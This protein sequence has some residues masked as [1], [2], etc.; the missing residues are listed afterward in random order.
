MTVI[1]TIRQL[2]FLKYLK[3]KEVTVHEYEFP[4]SKLAKIT[5]SFEKLVEKNYFLNQSAKDAYKSYIQAYASHQLKIIFDVHALDLKK[6]A[7]SF[8]LPAPPRCNL[9]FK[10]D[11]NKNSRKRNKHINDMTF[12]NKRPAEGEAKPAQATE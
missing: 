9:N 10:A 1:L 2:R 3:K 4:E 11:K 5:A 6:V 8:G 7:E 12:F